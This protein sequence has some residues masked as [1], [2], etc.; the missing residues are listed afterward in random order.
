MQTAVYILSVIGIIFAV[1]A[2]GFFL[3]IAFSIMNQ[4]RRVTRAL[5][6]VEASLVIKPNYQQSAPPEAYSK[7]G[8]ALGRQV[9]HPSRSK[10]TST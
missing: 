4:V 3:V 10:G 2:C 9:N 6:L 7:L 1:I 8:E 5:R